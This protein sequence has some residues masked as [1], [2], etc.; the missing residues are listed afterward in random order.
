MSVSI[1]DLYL[2]APELSLTILA[3]VVMM[4]DLFVKRRIVIVSVALVGLLVPLAFTISQIVTLGT[5][6]HRGFY[7]ML[8]VDPYSLFFQV[9]FLLIA[10]IMI[11]ASYNY[12]AKYVQ[13]DGGFIRSCCFL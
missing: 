2:L 11:L 1:G 12:V 13:A 8:V 3:L 7:N 9:V 10:I 5:T 6:T 4:V